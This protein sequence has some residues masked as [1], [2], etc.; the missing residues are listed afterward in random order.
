MSTPITASTLTR[1]QT[2]EQLERDR[3][4]PQ[5][6]SAVAISGFGL[7][8]LLLA[9]IGLYGILALSVAQRRRE[10]AIRVALGAPASGVV[11][12]AVGEG[13]PLV[14]IGLFVGAIGAASATRLLRA[15]LFE[16]SAYDPVTFAIV[17]I[18]LIAVALAASYLPARRA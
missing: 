6:F 14:V 12:L 3:R 2:M 16:T 15:A 17:P 13:M 11:R 7:A 10:M 1:V 18:V 9:A 8:A 4:A 5:R